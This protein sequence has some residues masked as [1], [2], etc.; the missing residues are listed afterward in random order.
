MDNDKLRAVMLEFIDRWTMEFECA[1]N[2]YT[3]LPLEK[4]APIKARRDVLYW[5]LADLYY[6]FTHRGFE[7]VYQFESII[8]ELRTDKR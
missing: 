4:Q 1:D 8:N 7:N 5:M 2:F 3:Q 6:R